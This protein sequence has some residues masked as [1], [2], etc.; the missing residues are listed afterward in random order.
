MQREMGGDEK[1]LE[2]DTIDS[3]QGGSG[4]GNRDKTPAI[5]ADSKKIWTL[6]F[7]YLA[8]YGQHSTPLLRHS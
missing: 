6:F 7:C 1:L 3:I 2:H 5:S 8:D 4:T